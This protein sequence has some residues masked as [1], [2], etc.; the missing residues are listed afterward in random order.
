MK[1]FGGWIFMATALAACSKRPADQPAVGTVSVGSA[2]FRTTILR[3]YD[4]RRR[5]LL[6]FGGF[7]RGEALL[8]AH[9]RDRFQHY[10]FDIAKFKDNLFDVAFL[11]GARVITELAAL[12][13]S[14]EGVTSRQECRY[15]LFTKSGEL[16]RAGARVGDPVRFDSTVSALPVEDDPVV[17]IDG[18]KIHVELAVT[19]E[20][21][22]RGYMYRHR[23]SR[24]EGILFVFPEPEALSF[25]MGYCPSPLSVAW[26]DR[27]LT[28]LK[29]DD[30]NVYPSWD[31]PPAAPKTWSPP[32]PV[33]YAL[34][35]RLGGFRELG[36]K[37]GSKVRLPPELSRY[38]PEQRRR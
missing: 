6:E 26:I 1:Y 7:E 21:R 30:M 23:I 29:L 25:W 8:I 22:S 9:A 34:E 20:Q 27:D 31:H 18:K 5:G 32:K 14:A 15:A 28:L 19:N 24:G 16:A 33:P 2:T 35:M 36:I 12:Q 13:P 37:E 3:T 10:W 17:E 11:D 38:K 4:E